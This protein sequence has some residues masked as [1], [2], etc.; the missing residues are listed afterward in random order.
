METIWR[1][2]SSCDASDDMHVHRVVEAQFRKGV[3]SSRIN[4]AATMS[5]LQ[6]RYLESEGTGQRVTG[7]STANTV[8]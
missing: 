4:S 6:L 3:R 7:D 8:D 1:V 2:D 5:A